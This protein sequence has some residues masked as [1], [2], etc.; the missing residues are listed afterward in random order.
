MPR[1]IKHFDVDTKI[2]ISNDES[3][4]HSRVDIVAKNKPGLLASV[5]RAF[6]KNEVK[7]HDA[8]I[9]T[10]G[11]KVEDSFLITDKS[12]NAITDK[13]TQDLIIETLSRYLN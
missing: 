1:Q 6:V 4:Q 7:I 2:S 13:K 12:N 9:T 3:T 11:E 5:G 10:L 8:K